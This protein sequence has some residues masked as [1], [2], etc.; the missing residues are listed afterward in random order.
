MEWREA[1]VESTHENPG[2]TEII[3]FDQKLGV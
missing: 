1:V 3:G 2:R